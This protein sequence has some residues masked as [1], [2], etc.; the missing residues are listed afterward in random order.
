[1]TS[2][3]DKIEKLIKRE[4][5]TPERKRKDECTKSS[6]E[7]LSELFSAFNADPPKIDEATLKKSKKSKKKHKKEK[8]SKRSRSCS[9]SSDS[10]TD[11]HK[12]KKRKKSKSKSK[13]KDKDKWERTPSL[14]RSRTPELKPD[15]EL[16]K[17][18]AI[19]K[20]DD[21]SVVNV[22]VAVKEEK[23]DK[24]KVEV[25]E[26]KKR[27]VSVKH[28]DG[29]SPISHS[30]DND[31]IPLPDMPMDGNLNTCDLRV[32]LEG[33]KCDS[34]DNDKSKGKIQIK[35]LKFSAVYEETVKKAEEEARKKAKMY[36]EGE[37][38]DSSS[39]S[40]KPECTNSQFPKS[41]DPGGILK[42]QAVEESKLIEEQ[43]SQSKKSK[44]SD[45]HTEKH[46]ESSHKSSKRDKDRSRSPKRSH[47][48]S[49][50]SRSRST[51]RRYHRS[52]SKSH[53]RSRSR[54]RSRS[55]SR[56]STSRT[57]A[58]R[59]TSRHR[60]RSRSPSGVKLADSEKKRLLEVARRNAIN[61]L[62]NGAVPAGAAALPPHTRN[63]VMAAIQS[64][65]KSV[66]E[67]T[68]F[69]KH[70]S[71]KEALGELSS[72]SSND[73]GMSENEDTIAFH[74]PFLVKEKAPIVMN[75]RGGA[76]LPVKSTSI[77]PV[78]NK[79]ELR[80]QFPVSSGSQ[81]RE[82]AS[83]WVPV[84][85]KKSEMQVAKLNSKPAAP[86]PVEP[87][88][89][90]LPVEAPAVPL[91]LPAPPAPPTP[92]APASEPVP[93][94]A[95]AKN[96]T[97]GT[98]LSTVPVLP[99]LPALPAPGPQAYPPGLEP[100]K[101]DYASIVSQKIAMIRKEQ[102]QSELG[103]TRGFGWSKE[104]TLGQFTG[105]TGAQ[106]L[107]PR[108]L[109]SGTQAWAKK[110]Q[111]TRAAPVEGGMGMHLLQK[112][113]WTPGQGL[114]KEGTGTLQPLLL[115]VKL[116]TKGLQA[117]EEAVRG[118]GVR[119]VRP[120]RRGPAPLVAGG[121]HPV[122]LL[123]EYC[124]KQK[125][126]PPE[127]DLCFEC[128]PDHKKNF[129]FKVKVAGVEYQPAVASANKKQA[130]ADAAQLALQKLGITT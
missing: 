38:T 46:S 49:H 123:G 84:S 5:T 101:V 21:K 34:G 72:V 103:T 83:E 60:R 31:H 25:K 42:K 81:H 16:I 95:Y 53:R 56:R 91:A 40:D 76:P 36:E 12:H 70:L 130:K 58:R 27:R 2:L 117:K 1:M 9:S 61:M 71:K 19:K 80:L 86:K 106:I 67:L 4:K 48:K 59:L 90:P 62:K 128:G 85:P 29:H 129:L 108:E 45:K 113:G 35:N 17:T 125:V 79:E 93:P 96:F 92:P 78:A 10:D 50:R 116:D 55:R 26:E 15:P 63:Q 99:V 119:A 20:E 97:S 98:Q 77:L 122:S 32:R 126:G 33:K 41:A 124:S 30:I 74:H 6:S 88:K 118:K 121:K 120:G 23:P 114:G 11:G 115:E 14:S 109:A 65:G 104:Q 105:S 52:S 112:M 57:R 37:Y 64:G 54:H 47:S 3:I 18:L 44:S 73:E 43:K 102:E 127:Y 24:V 100:P 107:T 75:I 8:K 110:D 66:D 28:E 68:D 87:P 69:C 111:L 82:K 39:C 7:I 13:R 94:P 51:S 89:P 22:K